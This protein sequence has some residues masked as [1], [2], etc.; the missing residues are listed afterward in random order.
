MILKLIRNSFT[1]KS[2]IG[3]LFIDGSYV[4]DVLEDVDRGLIITEHVNDI[5]KK[6]IHGQTAIPYGRYEVIINWSNRFKCL[7]PLLV[8]VP[9]YA[10]VR[11]H[12][13]NTSEHT[14]GCLLVGKKENADFISHSK[15]TYS[16]L[17]ERLNEAAKSEKIFIEITK[18]NMSI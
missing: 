6:K 1:H 9:G 17:F 12:S 14:E 11:I 7:M 18:D 13:G 2:T 15:D 4:C 8:N 3:Q 16:Q 5:A 10:G